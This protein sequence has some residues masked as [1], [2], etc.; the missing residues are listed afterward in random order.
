MATGMF[1]ANPEELDAV[2]N[3]FGVAGGAVNVAE[4]VSGT[5]VQGVIWF[6]LDATMFKADYQATVCTQLTMLSDVL[7]EVDGRLQQQAQDQTDASQAGGSGG[8]RSHGGPSLIDSILNSWARDVYK[9]WNLFRKPGQFV[10]FLMEAA[11]LPK[12]LHLLEEMLTSSRF[13]WSAISGRFPGAPNLSK[14]L[15][16][17]SLEGEAAKMFGPL[18]NGMKGYTDFLGMN[19]FS[20]K[21]EGLLPDKWNSKLVDF[22]GKEGRGLSRGLGALGVV[23]DG[24]ETIDAVNKGNIWSDSSGDITKGAAWNTAQTVLAA[25]SFVPGPVGWVSTGIS[26]GMAVYEN[27]DAISGAAKSIATDPVGTVSNGV[28]SIASTLNPFD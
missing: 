18:Y 7:E 14:L 24:A 11:A 25:T 21:L 27:W 23:F 15:A 2:G 8:G 13:N 10:R 28:K 4:N 19:G 22:V 12:N 9:L 17:T 16:G 1:G 5:A 3:E 20:K 26:A 6:G